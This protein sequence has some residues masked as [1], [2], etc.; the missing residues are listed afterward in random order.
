MEITVK[1]GDVQDPRPPN[2]L[3]TATP[4]P[5]WFVLVQNQANIY[6]L[7]QQCANQLRIKHNDSKITP[8]NCGFLVIFEWDM[9]VTKSINVE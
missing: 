3:I 9:E 5:F 8:E 1:I 2:T 6:C 7:W 4:L